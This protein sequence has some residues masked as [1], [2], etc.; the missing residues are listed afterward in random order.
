MLRG[1]AGRGRWILV[2]RCHPICEAFPL[3]PVVEA[4]RGI[5]DGLSGSRLSTVAGALRL[6]VPELTPWLPPMPGVVGRRT[7]R[8]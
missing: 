2:G 1:P 4:T 7:I 8:E 3:G 5:G 6:R